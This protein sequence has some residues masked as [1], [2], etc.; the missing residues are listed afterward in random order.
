VINKS[1]IRDLMRAVQVT[2]QPTPLST[3][4][5]LADIAASHVDDPTRELVVVAVGTTATRA[6][7]S[8]ATIDG[9][10]HAADG[11]TDL[12]LGRIGRCAW[13]TA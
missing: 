10:V 8:A 2:S 6:L 13:S 3:K 12:V 7:E 5:N 9:L 1:G 11:C 4:L